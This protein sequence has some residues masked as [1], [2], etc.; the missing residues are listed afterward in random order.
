[1]G[2]GLFIQKAATQQPE[3]STHEAQDIER[4][5]NHTSSEVPAPNRIG[6][7]TLLILTIP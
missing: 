2:G 6:K 3:H 1:M 5:T 7:C 4:H